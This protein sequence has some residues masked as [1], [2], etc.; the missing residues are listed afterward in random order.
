MAAS[1]IRRN[2]KM[3]RIL[4]DSRLN[5]KGGKAVFLPNLKISKGK[6]ISETVRFKNKSAMSRIKVS[7]WMT[8][9]VAALVSLS[10]EA[11]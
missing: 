10:P 1:P 7:V 5:T 6:E 4:P 3:E 8:A 11:P 9:V 2:G